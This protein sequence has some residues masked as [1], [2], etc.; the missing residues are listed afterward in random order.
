MKYFCLRLCDLLYDLSLILNANIWQ[1]L[2][3]EVHCPNLLYVGMLQ[4]Y[5]GVEENPWQN[6]ALASGYRR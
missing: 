3:V 4:K 1:E 6:Q 5:M 2:L